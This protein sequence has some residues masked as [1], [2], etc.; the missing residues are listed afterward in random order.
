M[1]DSAI[2]PIGASGSCRNCDAALADGQA[3]CGQ[4]GQKAATRRLTLVG[5]GHDLV[6]ALFHIDQS[7]FALLKGLLLRPGYVAREFVKGRRRKYFS[8]FAFAVITAGLATFFVIATGARWFS[9]ITDSEAQGILS[10]HINLVILLQT[11]VLTSLCWLLFWN[12]RMTFAEHLVLVAYTAGIRML[13]LSFVAAPV[14]YATGIT[15]ANPWFIAGYY[16]PWLVY[17][18]IASVQFYRGRA[19]VTALK[20]VVATTVNQVLTMVGIYAF[21]L[22]YERMSQ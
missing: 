2:Q 1:S 18:A 19:W 14:M 21:I 16:G 10:R 12:A 8:P 4:C 7:I 22:T 11:P 17:F 9:P 20:A 13:Y 3:F 6:H 15:S 5:I